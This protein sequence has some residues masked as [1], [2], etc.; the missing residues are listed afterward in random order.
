MLGFNYKKDSVMEVSKQDYTGCNSTR[1]NFFSNSGNTVYT[2]DRSGF[3]FFISGA[4]GHCEVG[5]RMIV[6]V[7]AQDGSGGISHASTSN[8]VNAFLLYGYLVILLVVHF[9]NH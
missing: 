8:N 1:P 6:W 5:Q 4:T 2:L 9:F 3:F 7:V